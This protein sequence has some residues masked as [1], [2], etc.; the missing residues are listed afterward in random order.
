MGTTVLDQ[1]DPT[2]A[3]PPHVAIF[4]YR[5]DQMILVSNGGIDCG[6]RST[7]AVRDVAGKY[8]GVK[9]VKLVDARADS[10]GRGNFD[11]AFTEVERLLANDRTICGDRNVDGNASE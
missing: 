11:A 9:L 2:S 5:S 1:A 8:L 3:T 7:G 6:H 10:V 4:A